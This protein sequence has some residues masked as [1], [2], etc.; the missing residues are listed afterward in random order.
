MKGGSYY[1]RGN[2]DSHAHHMKHTYAE[3]LSTRFKL[4]ITLTKQRKLLMETKIIKIFKMNK[5]NIHISI[6]DLKGRL[7]NHT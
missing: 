3:M 2:I 4:S 5:E 1:I 6:I 7:K